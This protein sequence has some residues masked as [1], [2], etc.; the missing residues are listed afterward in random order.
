MPAT[1]T[2]TCALRFHPYTCRITDTCTCTYPN[3]CAAYVH[4]HVT[5]HTCTPASTRGRAMLDPGP[6]FNM[7]HGP[8]A[9]ADSG[10]FGQRP[11]RTAACADSGRYGVSQ[12]GIGTAAA[13]SALHRAFHSAFH[14]VCAPPLPPPQAAGAAAAAAMTR[15][16]HTSCARAVR[17]RLWRIRLRRGDADYVWCSIT[18]RLLHNLRGPGPGGCYVLEHPSHR[19]QPSRCQCSESDSDSD[20]MFSGERPQTRGKTPETA[21]AC[22]YSIRGCGAMDGGM[23]ARYRS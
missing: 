3:S 2:R 9:G 23:S 4:V 13:L 11:V 6:S 22:T 14:S 1:T 17:R 10:R 20:G 19:N 5:K 12:L 21:A 8:A 7:R 18:S 15:I 16:G